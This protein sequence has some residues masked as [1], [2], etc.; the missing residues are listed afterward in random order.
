MNP[1]TRSLVMAAVR[2]GLMALSASL[3]THGWVTADQSQH[4]SS[5][6][7]VAGVTGVLI[8]LAAVAW[9][10]RGQRVV[11]LTALAMP[12]GT[13]E[14]ELHLAVKNGKVADAATPTDASPVIASTVTP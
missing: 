1:F 12:E 13:T 11:T 10:K 14:R 8:S 7:I 5:P 4:L 9:S 6:E 3:L 2:Q